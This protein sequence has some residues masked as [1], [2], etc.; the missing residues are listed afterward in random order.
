MKETWRWFGPADV[1]GISDI[2]QAGATGVVSALHHI[3]NGDVWTPDEIS[4]RH[5]QIATRQDGTASGLTWDVVESLPVSE[6]I[7]KQDGDWREHIANYK[8]SLEN[9]AASGLRVVCYNFMP[10]LDWTRTDLEWR[11]PN[12][13][14]CMRF[15]WIDFA[16]FDLF[17]LERP[18]AEQDFDDATKA[19]AAQ[20]YAEMSADDRKALISNVTQGLPG[21]NQELSFD[22]FGAL[23]ASYDGI[24]EAQLRSNLH[25]FLAEIIPVAERLGIR[26]CC[27]PDDPPFPLLGLPRIMST[28]ADYTDLINAVDSPSN[29][30]TLCSGSLGVDPDNDL[31]GMMKRLGHRVHF[32]HLRNVRREDDRF[33]GSF[34]EAAHLEGSTDMVALIDAVLGEEN[35]R[36]SQGREDW[37]IPM[38]PDHGHQIADDFN[39]AV[40]PGYPLIGR[41]RGLAELRGIV[42]ALTSR[43]ATGGAEL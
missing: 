31:P 10:V 2:E 3:P 30:I 37:N 41:L 21:A 33:P 20:R 42:A 18:G 43:N 12:R 35:L 15:D 26:M 5:L 39:R 7:K 28:E 32:L 40:Q 9:L 1:V 36:K 23:L 24:D 27:H 16:V 13:S 29:G 34:H 11:L 22:E 17:L 38:R 19:A 4:Q 25:V 8:T 6:D 14:T